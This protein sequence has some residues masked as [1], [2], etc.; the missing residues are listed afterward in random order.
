MIVAYRSAILARRSLPNFWHFVGWLRM[1]QQKI[2][3]ANPGLLQYLS[4]N[5]N[6]NRQK[7]SM[8][9]LEFQ[10]HFYSQLFRLDDEP[11]HYMKMV[12]SPKHPLNKL[13]F[14]G[15]PSWIFKQKLTKAW[16]LESDL[17]R[18]MTD[19]SRQAGFRA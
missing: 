13:F 15:L 2:I 4:A 5:K 6:T 12:V 7:K 19:R 14:F 11:N 18:E 1:N 10:Q 3:K 8:A 9:E 16:S 17:K